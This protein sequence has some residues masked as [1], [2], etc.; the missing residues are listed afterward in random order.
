MLRKSWPIYVSKHFI[1]KLKKTKKKYF[2]YF[3][4]NDLT[5]AK[6]LQKLILE[7]SSLHNIICKSFR[8]ILV[9][10]RLLHD[11]FLFF[12]Y[13]LFKKKSQLHSLM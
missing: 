9:L 13:V 2:L 8:L 1:R 10:W 3:A 6:V 7:I 4:P 11:S 5:E 12:P